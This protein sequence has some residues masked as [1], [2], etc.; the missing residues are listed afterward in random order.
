MI[1]FLD[2]EFTLRE[3]G[4]SVPKRSDD[5]CYA[6]CSLGNHSVITTLRALKRT[7]KKRGLYRCSKCVS[8]SEEGKRHR[9]LQA[10]T[11][12]S[13][14]EIASLISEKSKE[15]A[16]SEK[17]RAQRSLQSKKAW[18]SEPYSRVQKDRIAS[19]FKSEEHRKLVS[20]RNKKD[21]QE[22][23]IKYIEDKVSAMWSDA[24]KKKHKEALASPEY[25]ETHRQLAKTR[26]EN[27][28]YKEKIAKGL[29]NFPRG[30]KM[31]TPEKQV[32]DIL[33]ALVLEYVYNKA[34]GPYNF[35]FYIEKLN[36]YV[37][38]QGE[39]WHSLPNNERRDR[40]KFSY[41]RMAFPEAKL[42]YLWDYDFNSGNAE[43]KIREALGLS[44]NSAIEF[45]FSE[46]SLRTVNSTE[47]KPFLNSWHYA[48]YGKAA[49]F[50]YGVY[51]NELLISVCKI[52]P[53]SRKEV[54]SSEGFTPKECFE[55][56]RFCIHPFY[57]KKNLGS[58]LLSRSVKTFFNEFPQSKALVS[59][60]D[61]TFGHEGTIYRASNWTEVRK[62]K[63]D[64]IYVASDGWILH[65]KT[66]YNQAVSVH[67]TETAY[68]SKHGYKKVFGK[69][70]T[71][72]ITKRSCR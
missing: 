20:E 59:F 57:H 10:I 37:E 13:N 27:D 60:S 31:S 72:F 35:D 12:W 71:K 45:K 19:L 39:Y 25:R 48:Q 26:F 23:P 34:V 69:E 38:V 9:S 30:G 58:F 22:N 42:I 53:V 49:K 16:N 11:L 67:M 52:G 21:Y 8:N 4:Y 68:A 15:L 2:S 43:Y 7:L 1:E 63:P 14:P 62:V 64:Y 61:S 40:A 44:L 6:K 55:L 18:E 41:L 70:K 36:L 46:C 3:F 56:D 65:K 29:E 50:L 33:E 5:K 24:A 32:K 28:E 51:L 17:G 66:L 54:A 47:A